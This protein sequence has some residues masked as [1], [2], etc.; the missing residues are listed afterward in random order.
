MGGGE[1]KSSVQVSWSFNKV[2][3]DF[4]NTCCSLAHELPDLVL[5]VV[6]LLKKP[7]GK[8]QPI[9]S[10]FTAPPVFSI[11]RGHPNIVPVYIAD[12]RHRSNRTPSVP[13]IADYAFATETTRRPHA[14]GVQHPTPFVLSGVSRLLVLDY[15]SVKTYIAA[16]K[17]LACHDD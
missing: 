8:F 5:W 14:R 7:L 15:F 16:D 11:F 17:C 4:L 1:R 12:I 13:K 2:V 3:I 6:V 10:Y 9:S